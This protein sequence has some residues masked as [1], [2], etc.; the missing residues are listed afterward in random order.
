MMVL[1]VETYLTGVYRIV[2]WVLEADDDYFPENYF[3][4]IFSIRDDGV[5]ITVNKGGGGE[6]FPEESIPESK[7]HQYR[8]CDTDE[9]FQN[10]V[11]R[12]EAEH[13]SVRLMWSRKSLVRRPE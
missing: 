13:R 5:M 10:S 4:D 1:Y 8:N 12:G 3:W 7:I 2:Y 6:G 9:Y 11:S